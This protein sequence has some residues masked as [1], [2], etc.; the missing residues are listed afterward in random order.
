MSKH[1]IKVEAFLG[2]MSLY[3]D[4]KPLCECAWLLE[5]SFVCPPIAHSQTK[6]QKRERKK[7]KEKEKKETIGNSQYSRKKVDITYAVLLR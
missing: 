3:I 1:T 7:K 6:A 4:V 2:R 5:N